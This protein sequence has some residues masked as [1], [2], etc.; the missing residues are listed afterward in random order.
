[1][2]F[3]RSKKLSVIEKVLNLDSK[4][5]YIYYNLS[6]SYTTLG[7]FDLAIENANKVI[8]FGQTANNYFSRGA[9]FYYNDNFKSAI[10]D[11]EKALKLDPNDTTCAEHLKLAKEALE[12]QITETPN[13]LE[14]DVLLEMYLKKY[15]K[16]KPTDFLL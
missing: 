3:W 9:A 14:M 4:V 2:G 13:H 12:K 7:K 15:S 6:L 1:M 10:Q 11:F 8:E 16:H 5:E